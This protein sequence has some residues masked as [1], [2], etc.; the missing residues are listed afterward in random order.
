LSL[1]FFNIHQVERLKRILT[2]EKGVVKKKYNPLWGEGKGTTIYGG[3]E[4]R[5]WEDQPPFLRGDPCAIGGSENVRRAR[6]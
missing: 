1:I 2:E 4:G 3:R 5:K 6:D